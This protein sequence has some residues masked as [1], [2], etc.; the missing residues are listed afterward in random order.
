MIEPYLL[1]TKI[2]K[3]SMAL[4]TDYSFQEIANHIYICVVHE[5]DND[6]NTIQNRTVIYSKMRMTHTEIKMVLR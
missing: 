3:K 2:V 1:L 5:Y 4:T 6:T